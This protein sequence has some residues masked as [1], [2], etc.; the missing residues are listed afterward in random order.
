LKS[1]LEQFKKPSRESLPW[2]IWNW[3]LTLS[4]QAL[5]EQCRWFHESGFGGVL[6]RPSRTMVPSYLSFEFYSHVTKILEYAEQVGLRVRL[7]DDFSLSW[8]DCFNQELQQNPKS[9]ARIL[10]LTE[11]R[12]VS[13]RQE[14]Q[15]TCSTP[16]EMIVV[17]AREENG[18]IDPASVIEISSKITGGVLRWQVPEGSWRICVFAKE[19]VYSP[20]GGYVPNTFSQKTA[21]AY[22]QFVLEPFKEHFSKYIPGILEGFINELPALMPAKNSIPWDDDLVVKF[23]SKSKKNLIKLLPALFCDNFP[24]AQKNRQQIYSFIHETTGERFIVPLEEWAKKNKMSQW[25][26]Y[27]DRSLYHPS[28][29]L[30]DGY[31]PPLAEITSLGYQ[32]I[33]GVETG[34]VSVRIASDVNANEF[35]RETISV[36][37]RNRLGTG[38]TIGSLK[39]DVDRILMAGASRI[40]IDGFFANVDQQSYSKV[41]TSPGWYSPEKEW[42][43]NVCTY[44]TCSNEVVKNVHW[45]RQIAVLSPVAELMASFMP[46]GSEAACVTVAMDRL[47]KTVSV[48]ERNGYSYD[49]VTEQLL[50]ACSIR[51]NGEFGTQDRIRKGNYQALIIPFAPELSRNVLIFIEKLVQK[52]GCVLFIDEAPSGTIEDGISSTMTSRFEKILAERHKA[53]GIVTA[54]A[55]E[56]SLESIVPSMQLIHQGKTSFEIATVNGVKDG[57]DLYLVHNV[58]AL[59]D[60]TFMI[61]VADQPHFALVNCELGAMTSIQPIERME[62]VARFQMTLAPKAMVVLMGSI[63]AV[64]ESDVPKNISHCSNPFEGPVRN[65]RILVKD[66]WLFS[67]LSANN[68]PLTAWNKRIGLSRDS[69]GFSHFYE[70]HFQVKSLPTQCRLVVNLAGLFGL[71]GNVLPLE[72]NINGTKVD[73]IKNSVSLGNPA[74]AVPSGIDDSFLLALGSSFAL[75]EIGEHLVRGANRIS[76]RTVEGPDSTG[77]MLFPPFLSGDFIVSKG[78][79]GGIIDKLEDGIVPGSWVKNGFPC[80][81]GKGEY[82][83]SFELPND[84]EKLVLCFPHVSGAIEVGMNGKDLG[85]YTW[86]PMC[87]DITGACEQRRNEL[88]VKVTNSIDTLLRMNGRPSGL[89]GDV[90]LDVY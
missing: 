89:I 75:F 28:T 80:L 39:S 18:A 37:G 41:P 60:H 85:V 9:R 27:P 30:I 19:F 76:L 7:A 20:A 1:I 50:T 74:K 79:T 72:I 49:L 59:K 42:L 90:Y 53:T 24:G 81:F 77:T 58:S 84:Y 82:R 64:P 52:E 47:K 33:D 43:K 56:E 86:Q 6:I 63:A 54:D 70:T 44:I 12:L 14:V 73:N 48:L 61:E 88:T 17:A 78:Q 13:E 68:Y 3:N 65:Y 25:V 23:R 21:A 26:L 10:K 55:F 69:G 87:V 29:E 31:I 83:Q 32:N 45:N 4:S 51:N 71:T 57:N 8:V 35:R 46:S 11:E 5:L 38:A 66:Q 36:I 67:P 62:N 34:S 22:I 16:D 2:A 40:L 15:L